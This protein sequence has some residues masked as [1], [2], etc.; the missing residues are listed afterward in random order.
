MNES[1]QNKLEEHCLDS[2]LLASLRDGEL[3]AEELAGVQAHL[4]ACPGCATE[5]RSLQHTGHEIY[6]LFSTLD[7]A[8]VTDS[9]TSAALARLQTQLKEEEHHHTA[10]RT[11]IPMRRK[12]ASV[13]SGKR[14]YG[15][16]WLIAAVA[17]LLLI[18]LVAPNAQVLAQQFLSLFRVQ[19]FQAVS[20]NPEQVNRNLLTD[21]RDFGTV[22][23]TG[24]NSS[25][26]PSNPTQAQVEQYTHIHVLLPTQLPAGVGQDAHFAIFGGEQAT[27][28]FNASTTRAYMHQIG[29][30]NVTLPANLDGA[31][32][33]I[34]VAPGA[35]IT[36]MNNCQSNTMQPK[37]LF[38]H[39]TTCQAGTNFAMAEVP[40]PVI[41]SSGQASI[42]DLRAFLLSLP[43]LPTPI[44]N[45]ALHVDETTGTVPVPMPPQA[46]SQ[47]VTVNGASGI[48]LTDPD[49]H[50]GAVLW[51][52]Q[53][54][55]YMITADVDNGTQLM[56]AANSLR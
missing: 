10:S 35:L 4:A 9:Q 22:Q 34:S 36:Y 37:T 23:V 20:I 7:A 41:E 27:F 31:T 43:H 38:S 47:N 29:D 8:P 14:T 17:A 24:N 50:I 32:Y 49:L 46:N 18:A 3:T 48:L 30:G 51:Q 33:H 19:Q 5:A 28:V 21:L 13:A 53:G 6:A 56:V 15:M 52:T 16:R 44:H 55:V 42:G 2:G 39:A 26:Y 54:M 11:P 40:S 25:T 1:P 12:G 45:L